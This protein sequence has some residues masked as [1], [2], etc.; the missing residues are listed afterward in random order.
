[1]D[2]PFYFA[3]GHLLKYIQPLPKPSITR[4]NRS[5]W[6]GKS[7]AVL[8]NSGPMHVVQVSPQNVTF[9]SEDALLVN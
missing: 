3:P 4:E 7:Y 1:M 2:Y 5:A 9:P 6:D 8:T